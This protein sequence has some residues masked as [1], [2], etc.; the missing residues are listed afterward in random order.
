MYVYD[1]LVTPGRVTKNSF[2]IEIVALII[3]TLR[4]SALPAFASIAMNGRHRS[5]VVNL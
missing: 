4:T 5:A 3:S 2:Q 1:V